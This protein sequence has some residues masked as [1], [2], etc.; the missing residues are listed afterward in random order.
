MLGVSR[1]GRRLVG[2]IELE[3]VARGREQLADLPELRQRDGRR[4]ATE[5]VQAVD[6]RLERGALIPGT[7]GLVQIRVQPRDRHLAEDVGGASLEAPP[8]KFEKIPRSVS[9]ATWSPRLAA[10]IDTPSLSVVAELASWGSARGAREA[11]V[12]DQDHLANAGTGDLGEDLEKAIPG[13]AG[14]PSRVT[15]ATSVPVPAP[16]PAK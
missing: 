1:L 2:G 6:V 7:E 8:R 13:V 4:A 9:P 12:E 11:A 3:Q 16:C 5:L 15:S 14:V 10:R